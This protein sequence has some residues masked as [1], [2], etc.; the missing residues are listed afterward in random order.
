ML[1]STLGALLID[2]ALP[3]AMRGQQH[4]LDSKGLAALMQEVAEKYPGDYRQVVHRLTNIGR[5]V[6]QSTGSYSFG[7]KHIQPSPVYLETRQRLEKEI[8]TILDSDMDEDEKHERIIKIV[9]KEQKPLEEKIYQEA[10]AAKNPLAIQVLSGSR[11]KPSNLKSLLG[12]DLLYQDHKDNII[13]MPVLRGYGEGLSPAE[14]FAGSF[15]ARQGTI[16]TKMA[17]QRAGFFGKQIIQAAHRLMI[18]RHDAEGDPVHAMRGLPVDTDD[19]DNEGSLLSFPAGGYPRNTPLTARVMADLKDQ[20][21]HRIVA[22]SPIVGGPPEGGVYARDIGIRERGGVSPV[23]DMVGIAAAQAL[24]EPISQ[25]GLSAKHSGGVAGAGR[26]VSGFNHLNQLVQVPKAFPGGAA[27]AESDG[28]IHGVQEAP[29]GGYH[30]SIGGIKHFIAPGFPLKVKAGDQ[31]EAGDVLSEGIPN[32]SKI[33]EHKG[34][35]EGRKYFVHAFRHALK[36]AGISGHRRNIEVLARGLINHVRMTDEMGP[37]SPGDVV[38]YDQMEHSWEPREGVRTVNPKSAI[39]KYLEKPVLHHTIGTKIRP[40]ML[41]DFEDFGV[42]TLDVHDD[43][44]P[45]EPEMIRGME[46]L[47][48]DPDWLTKMLG[49]NIQKNLLADVH[50]GSVSDPAGTSYV[51]ALANPV[52]FGRQGLVRGF[53]SEAAPKPT[54]RPGGSVLDL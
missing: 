51:P 14:Y 42:K 5:E 4:K 17:T 34:V 18:T 9:G 37:H 13:P 49:S 43:P 39:G 53:R 23:G 27:H 20:G 33:V 38:G 7:L 45:F 24:S 11:G 44:P 30:L 46:N 50:R 3:E 1:R 21:I 31:V 29:A 54:M 2:E 32:P 6:A 22:R 48:H 41:K 35:G 52:N 12:A 15:G 47:S 28:T 25:G 36:D 10:L 40:S 19:Q 26:S 16:S 8:D